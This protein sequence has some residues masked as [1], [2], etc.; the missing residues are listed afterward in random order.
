MGTL[1]EGARATLCLSGLMLHF[2]CCKHVI[3]AHVFQFLQTTGPSMEPTLN[4]AGDVV[5]VDG[6]S[7]H[8]RR[9]RR[10]EVVLARSPRDPDALVVKRVRGLPLDRVR[11]RTSARA[12]EK[13]ATVPLAHVWLEGDNPADS[14]DSREYGAVPECMIKGRVVC[15]LW[16]PSAWGRLGARPDRPAFGGAPKPVET[17]T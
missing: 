15:R 3:E 10:G 5:L 9:P 13:E 4:F 17:A 2:Y 11:Y 14:R 8:W 7:Y 12:R 6:L 16:P 1:R